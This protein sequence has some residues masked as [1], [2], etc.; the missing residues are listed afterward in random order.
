MCKG[1]AAHAVSW[2]KVERQSRQGLVRFSDWRLGLCKVRQDWKGS[3]GREEVGRGRMGK[4]RPVLGKARRGRRGS[5]LWELVSSARCVLGRMGKARR[6]N[7]R[8]GV[9]GY[10]LGTALLDVVSAGVGGRSWMALRERAEVGISQVGLRSVWI[11][12]LIAEEARPVP[13]GPG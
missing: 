11:G 2:K 4:E 6:W 9:V 13:D 3:G 8:L 5:A 12:R 1:E 7:V 10:P